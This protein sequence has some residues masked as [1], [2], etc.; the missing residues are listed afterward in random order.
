MI[1]CC[2]QAFPHLRSTLCP[3]DALTKT[4]IQKLLY[5]ICAV[6]VPRDSVT[7]KTKSRASV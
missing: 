2:Q 5:I 7:I 6:L 1:T 4:E 3:G